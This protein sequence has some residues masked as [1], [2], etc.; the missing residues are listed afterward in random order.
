M[1]QCCVVSAKC[2][3]QMWSR[4]S[5]SPRR[6][7][8]QT[9]RRHHLSKSTA[10]RC[11]YIGPGSSPSTLTWTTWLQIWLRCP[12]N[13]QQKSNGWKKEKQ[14]SRLPA[15]HFP[16][17]QYL[18]E[19][20]NSEMR[21]ERNHKK[22]STNE[23]KWRITYIWCLKVNVQ[24]QITTAE[25]VEQKK[26][27]IMQYSCRQKNNLNMYKHKNDP[28]ILELKTEFARKANQNLRFSYLQTKMHK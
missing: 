10:G 24:T 1:L 21:W 13:R 6:C 4:C 9:G 26:T 19:K 8:R 20:P 14:N 2:I 25:M 27:S 3:P 22:G 5:A 28:S 23:S 11:S 15:K 17:Q 16:P 18:K 12:A 7:D